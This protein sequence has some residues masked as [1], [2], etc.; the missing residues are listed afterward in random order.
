VLRLVSASLDHNCNE[1]RNVLLNQTAFLRYKCL[2]LTVKFLQCL[3]VL[4]AL[5]FF[6]TVLMPVSYA[7]GSNLSAQKAISVPVSSF[8]VPETGIRSLVSSLSY[9]FSGL[10]ADSINYV[11][12]CNATDSTCGVCGPPLTLITTG[13]PIPYAAADEGGTVHNIP[14]GSIAAYLKTNNLPASATPYHIGLYVQ[15]T[16]QTCLS[17]SQNCSTNMDSNQMPLCMNATYDGNTVTALT[18][19]DN[20]QVDL[21]DPG[22]QYGYVADQQGVIYQCTLNTTTHEGLFNACTATPSTS[23]PVWT[24]RTIAFATTTVGITSS[25]Y[26]YVADVSGH[27]VYQCSLNTIGTVETLNTC[28]ITPAFN[29][30]SWEPESVTLAT[31]NSTQYA[32]VSDSLNEQIWRCALTSDG[33]L[34]GLSCMTTPASGAPSWHPAGVAFATINQT[35]YAYVAD[36]QSTVWQCPLE[37]D[38]L[39]VSS[40]CLNMSAASS[41]SFQTP[42]GITF[43]TLSNGIQYAYVA[44]GSTPGTVWQCVLNSTSGSFTSCVA[45]APIPAVV[46]VPSAIAFATVNNTQYGYVADQTGQVYQCTLSATGSLVTCVTT[47]SSLTASAWLPVGVAFVA[48]EYTVG[49]T[50][51][52]IQGTGLVLQNNLGDPLSLNAD[53]SFAFSTPLPPGAAYS[54]TVLTQPSSPAQTCSVSNGSGSVGSA[55]VITVAVTCASPPGAP[56]IGTATAGN[57]QAT[58]S[59]TAPTSD[60]G[61]PITSYT[62]TSSP[63]GLIAT[64]ASSPLTVTGLS[65]GTAYTFTV[66]ATNAAGT[67]S[68]SSASNSVTPA[69]VPGA[70][71]IGSAVGGNAQATVNFT[72]P[73]SNGGATITSYRATSSPGGF[74]VTGASSPLTVTGLSNGTPY[75]FR[76]TATNSAGTGSASAA[77]NSVTPATVPGAPFNLNAMTG[78]SGGTV[79][80]FFSTPS[81]GGSAITSYTAT[82]SPGGLT[83]SAATPPILVTGLTGGTSYTFT[84]TATNSVGTGP[85]SSPSNSV[86]P[87]TTVPGAPTIGSAVGGNAQATVNFTAPASN[88][89]ATITSYRATSSPGGFT[90]TGASSPLTVTGLSNGTPYTFRVTATNSVG[91]SLPSAASNSVTPPG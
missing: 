88:G 31:V 56:T 40:G 69:T 71:T 63:G 16:H 43:A 4:I 30:P 24:P 29:E 68:A 27:H 65:N 7:Q 89:G 36:E 26:A 48:T 49:G 55:N 72:A 77:S 84:V 78:S 86:T 9:T 14:S 13:T 60:G 41:T 2:L 42:L 6:F 85:A 34:D 66:T 79:N 90:V 28:A 82:S 61:S 74:T 80:V 44:D 64:G 51:S 76:V 35:Q 58:V 25:Q 70:P 22:T 37:S 33:A 45:Q 53:G 59:F 19:T 50:L 39:F 57:A 67:G 81:N 62:A 21:Q 32:Y 5:L 91:T 52:G 15:S 18:K 8:F 1:A 11:R 20:G 73:A 83:Q 3:Y 23:A 46:W 17:F 87:T 47:P 10:S 75:T 12:L 38:G 54:V